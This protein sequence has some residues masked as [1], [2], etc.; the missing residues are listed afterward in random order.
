[1]PFQYHRR[2]HCRDDNS[3]PSAAHEVENR[4]S[5]CDINDPKGSLMWHVPSLEKHN[6]FSDVSFACVNL[7]SLVIEKRFLGPAIVFEPLFFECSGILW[8]R[9]TPDVTDVRIGAQREL[10]TCAKSHS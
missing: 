4:K 7:R 10:V 1:M 8:E 5:S 3:S 2:P 6:Y 9:M